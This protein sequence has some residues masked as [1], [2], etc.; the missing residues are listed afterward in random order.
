MLNYLVNPAMTPSSE[1]SDSIERQALRMAPSPYTYGGGME[2]DFYDPTEDGEMYGE[3]ELDEDADLMGDDDLDDDD[4]FGDDDDLEDDD[5]FGG[6]EDEDGDDDFGDDE[7]DL[8]DEFGAPVGIERTNYARLAREVTNLIGKGK[9]NTPAAINKISRLRALW[10]RL[11]AKPNGTSGLD[12][13][14][15]ILGEAGASAPAA[16]RPMRPG[17]ARPAAPGIRKSAPKIMPTLPPLRIP[18]QP[19]I[20]VTNADR[21]QQEREGRF[22]LT[23]PDIIAQMKNYTVEKLLSIASNP[24][25]SPQVRQA[26][27]DELAKR[28][29]GRPGPG[30]R[31]PRR[32]VV[33]VQ[34]PGAPAAP[35][36]PVATSMP[37]GRSSTPVF[38]AVP[39][40][41]TANN[42]F[43]AMGPFK[44]EAALLGIG[45]FLLGAY[46]GPPL[47]RTISR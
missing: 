40:I 20:P 44:A 37:V 1:F 47:L 15:E 9:R 19:G 25:R 31:F 16:A 38:G 39:R 17:V 34:Q 27:R 7:D 8:D 10:K 4:D 35:A 30:P 5:D 26:A 46:A 32:P 6:D 43:D 18:S 23:G 13:P 28:R 11:S 2:S 21:I 22:R 29:A 3:D 42:V 45:V 24:N 33:V 36:A 14:A 12:S 41:V